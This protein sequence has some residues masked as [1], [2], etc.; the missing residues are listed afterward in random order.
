MNKVA[1]AEN[2]T[3]ADFN[4]A[5]RILVVDDVEDNRDILTRRLVRRGYEVAEAA[6]G[7]EALAQLD[8]GTFD[9]VLLDIMMPDLNGNEVL[10][11]LRAQYSSAELPVIMVTAK[12]Q[13]EDVVESLGL[14]AND[15]VTKPVDISIAVARINS[16]LEASKSSRSI[17]DSK[18]ILEAKTEELSHAVEEK[19]VE[20]R[21]EFDR[22]QISEE[23]LHFLAYHDPLT[24]MLNR[25]GFRDALAHA[26]TESHGPGIEPALLFIDL[27]GFK[28]VND[29]HGHE[30]GDKLLCAVARQMQ[31]IVPDN[32][33]IA[34][35]GGDEFAIISFYE[36]QPASSMSMAEKLVEGLGKPFDIDGSL[37]A[38]GA[39]CGVARASEFSSDLDGL[40]KGAD[41]AMYHAKS[42]GRGGAVLFEAQMLKDQAERRQLEADLRL[43]VQK[44]EFEIFYQPLFDMSS[45]AITGFEALV[46]WP[47]PKRGLISP[48]V[49]IPIAEETGLINQLGG[50]VLREAC[51]EAC[52]WPDNI[53]I[54]VNLSPIQFSSAALMPTLVNALG[55]SGLSPKRLELEITEMSL[56]GNEG[57][58]VQLLNAIRELGVKVSMDDFGT[59][60]S[61]LTYLRNFRFDKIKI[62]RRFVQGLD[63]SL[64]DS[65]IVDAIISLGKSI[66]IGTTAEGIETEDQCAAIFDRGCVEGQGY[67]FSRPLTSADALNFIT[68]FKPTRKPEAEAGK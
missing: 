58:N 25:Q 55:S 44:S 8:K 63:S 60:Y 51:L 18:K 24:K 20:L 61:S 31:E 33:V 13:S 59:G 6:G 23:K 38:I 57:K 15:Y 62:D 65:A 26:V 30:T 64:S 14:G 28:A 17:R 67:F 27:D 48:E 68:N 3:Q 21:V 56:L 49:F 46:R 66:G 45:R 29:V 19:K 40:V 35:L 5:P 9:L 43:A 2:D 12:S 50:W 32:F 36:D 54:A 52:K 7:Y 39:S 37:I 4:Q 11:R 34:R 42:N 53:K 47:H 41:L 22:R 10:R 1:L 16:Q